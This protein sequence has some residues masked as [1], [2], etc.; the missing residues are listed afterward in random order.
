M[1]GALAGEANRSLGACRNV[2]D[3]GD[4][5]FCEVVIGARY[6]GPKS[7]FFQPLTKP[8]GGLHS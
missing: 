1:Y 8:G 3:P 4:A 2:L 5:L 6:F 7:L